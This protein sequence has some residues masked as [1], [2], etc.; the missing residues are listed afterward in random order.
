[1]NDKVLY[2]QLDSN[3]KLGPEWI[4]E[5]PH[6][7]SAN[8]KLLS[9]LLEWNALSLINGI[10][11]KCVGKITKRRITKKVKEESIID[12]VIGCEEIVS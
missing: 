1:M 10:K 6:K 7:Q 5:D 11:T 3:S 4:S 2:I 8:G 12:F 9:D